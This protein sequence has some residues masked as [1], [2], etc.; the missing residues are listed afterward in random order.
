MKAT[1]E[2]VFVACIFRHTSPDCRVS[3]LVLCRGEI[4]PCAKL[5]ICRPLSDLERRVVDASWG[6]Q[7]VGV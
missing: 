4:C 2:H 5:L 1:D 6:A 7:V 3:H